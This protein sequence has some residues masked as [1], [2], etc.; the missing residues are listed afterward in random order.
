MVSI[1][2][3]EDYEAVMSRIEE[4]LKVVTDETPSD[5]PD[6]L[7]LDILSD[8]VEEYEDIHYPFVKPVVE[9]GL[10]VG[11]LEPTLSL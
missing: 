1:R 7:E 3:D 10:H 6:Y 11:K 5:S 9:N 8:M 2:N 4:L